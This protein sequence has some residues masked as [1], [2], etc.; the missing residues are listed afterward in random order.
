MRM[1]DVLQSLEGTGAPS[2]LWFLLPRVAL[3]VLFVLFCLVSLWAG[4]FLVRKIVGLFAKSAG[5]R[6]SL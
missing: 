4:V 5:E 2:S 6:Q 3:V 1:Q